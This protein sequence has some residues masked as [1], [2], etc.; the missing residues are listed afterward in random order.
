MQGTLRDLISRISMFAEGN[1]TIIGLVLYSITIWALL[2]VCSDTRYK[3]KVPKN[4]WMCIMLVLSVLFTLFEVRT[5]VWGFTLVAIVVGLLEAWVLYATGDIRLSSEE[6]CS[7]VDAI[8]IF[9]EKKTSALIIR[10]I[11]LL[12]LAVSV[13]CAAAVLY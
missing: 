2:L 9:F 12:A 5:G 6:Y 3:H 13:I 11:V 10:N 8:M 4:A 1:L 7:V